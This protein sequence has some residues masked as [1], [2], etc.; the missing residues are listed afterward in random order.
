ML[1]SVF[2]SGT[3]SAFYAA[4]FIAGVEATGGSYARV[5]VT[6]NATNFPAAA[7]GVQANGAKVSF[8]EATGTWGTVNE[9]RFF[10][11][12]SAGNEWAASSASVAKSIAAGDT[13]S[14][15]AGALTIT[16]T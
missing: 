3:P 8:P 16:V 7:A 4:A 6:N 12:S 11:A 15:D 1:D 10:D 13:L 2:G 5:A 14:F 9:V